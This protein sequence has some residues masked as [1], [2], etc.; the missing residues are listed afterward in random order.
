MTL[1][2]GET[3]ADFVILGRVGTGE[4]GEAYLVSDGQS[5]RRD[6]LTVLPADLTTD[7]A[8]RARFVREAELAV[9]LSHPHILDVHARGEDDGRFWI[10]TEFVDGIRADALVRDRYP[11]GLPP[12]GVVEIVDSIAS[13]LDY[14]HGKGLLHRNVAPA[15]ILISQSDSPARRIFL[16]EV[17]IARPL[18]DTPGLTASDTGLES[19]AF[20][21]PEQLMGEDVDPRSDQYALACTAFYLLTGQWPYPSTNAAVIINKH[22]MAP[23]PSIGERRPDLARLDGVFATAMA[24]DLTARFPSC[25]D[26]AE[27]LRRGLLAS[28]DDV[29]E[30]PIPVPYPEAGYAPVAAVRASA[31]PSQPRPSGRVTRKWS[32]EALFSGPRWSGK[33]I[34]VAALATLGIIA[35]AGT[36]VFGVVSAFVMSR[37][38]QAAP[39]PSALAPPTTVAPV[40]GKPLAVR[41]VLDAP[42]Q[43]RPDQCPVDAPPAPPPQNPLEA[44]AIDGQA[45]YQLGPVV[46]R[47]DLTS[48]TSAKLPMSDVYGVQ[49]SMDA[50]SGAAFAQY[51]AANVGTQLAFVRDGKVL[52]APSITEPISGDSLQISGQLTG[53]AAE[54][55]ARMLRDGT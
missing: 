3:F 54:T 55:I 1:T 50:A 53:E 38:Q 34:M 18:E 45:V 28:P 10:T 8:Y 24:K 13:A 17:G 19:V 44:C 20:T 33:K 46:L 42:L 29:A 43:P 51:T 27:A 49:M 14:V 39:P 25:L 31:G 26:F 7:P 2:V 36:I 52:A 40:I 21:A 11:K 15:N 30:A 41:T 16:E 6:A 5:S 9:T 47:L 48:A 4:L 12:E 23:P 35:M 22:V 32:R 37:Q